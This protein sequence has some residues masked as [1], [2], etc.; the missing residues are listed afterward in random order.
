[1]INYE[2]TH[3]LTYRTRVLANFDGYFPGLSGLVRGLPK[4][5]KE[6][7]ILIKILLP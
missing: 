2:K 3:K 5:S 4:V 6:I 1:M 7:L